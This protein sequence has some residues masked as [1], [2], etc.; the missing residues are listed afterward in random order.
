[1]CHEHVHV[2]QHIYNNNTKYNILWIHSIVCVSVSGRLVSI[3]EKTVCV[4]CFCCELLVSSYTNSVSLKSRTMCSH[5]HTR[6]RRPIFTVYVLERENCSE[7]TQY[8]SPRSWTHHQ[9]QFFNLFLKHSKSMRVRVCSI[10]TI[11]SVVC[12]RMKIDG[13]DVVAF[14]I[15]SFLFLFFVNS[16]AHSLD[17][18]SVQM[19][20]NENR[21]FLLL[22][23]V[24]RVDS[25]WRTAKTEK[26]ALKV[27]DATIPIQCDGVYPKRYIDLCCIYIFSIN[28]LSE[29]TTREQ[30]DESLVERKTSKQI[31]VSQIKKTVIHNNKNKILKESARK[32]KQIRIINTIE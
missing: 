27:Q 11:F 22:V 15:F 25:V 19:T 32:S 8:G 7:R 14:Q 30:R 9:F 18:F 28:W 4:S 13:D 16:M 20:T 12:P 10:H 17:R 2:S 21:W 24:V 29:I 3:E 6:C 23:W 26:K 5:T 1:M 31:K